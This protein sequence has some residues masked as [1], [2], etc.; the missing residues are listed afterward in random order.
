MSIEKI[1]TFIVKHL[2]HSK[3]LRNLLNSAPT[4]NE[5]RVETQKTKLESKQIE[6][7][8]VER[9]LKRLLLVSDEEEDDELI[10]IEY[11]KARLRKGNLEKD[12]KSLEQEVNEIESNFAISHFNNVVDGFEI[13]QSFDVVKA[14]IHSL[15]NEIRVG[16]F[17]K[18]TGGYFIMKVEYRRFEDVS[19]FTTDY[20]LYN[21]Y[22]TQYYRNQHITDREK[23]GDKELYE[24]INGDGAPE[25]FEGYET[26][27]I[28]HEQIVFSKDE[29]ITFN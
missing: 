11:K 19:L 16:H 3:T 2:F 20:Q 5:T 8:K 6:L 23:L 22:W 7:K 26:T 18:D 25:D 17:K 28:M 13:K 21:W 14:S 10:A 29:L 27:S 15:I 24:Y 1:E 4:V 9:Q 12:I